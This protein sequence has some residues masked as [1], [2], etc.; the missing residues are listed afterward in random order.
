MMAQDRRALR[1]RDFWMALVLIGLALF[2]LWRTSLL[3]FFQASAAG[4]EADWY[5]S[6][7]LVPYAIFGI[8]LA[9]A[10]GLLVVSIRDGG[11]PWQGRVPEAGFE[12]T[13]TIRV[14]ALAVILLTYIFG[15]VPRV[16]F[17]LCSGLA[18][19]ALIGGFHE[20]RVR[21]PMIAAGIVLVAGAYA[22]ITHFPQSE[23]N[24]PHDDDIVTL[25]AFVSLSILLMVEKHRSQGQ[26]GP[27]PKAAPVI[28]LLVPLFLVC[29]MAFGFRQNVPNRGGLIF[30]QIQ[31][32]YYVNLQPLLEGE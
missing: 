1:R 8:L 21:P 18:L 12:R 26:I 32:Q 4:V 5:S 15:L 19:T 27:I 9:M 6:A 25:V 14:V 22:A 28:G 17:I 30:S 2:F 23:W 11:A 20:A 31:Y 13:A 10:T 29:A 3:P 16:D 24:D 7:A